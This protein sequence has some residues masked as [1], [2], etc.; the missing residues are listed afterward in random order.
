MMSTAREERSSAARRVGVCCT[1]RDGASH[2]GPC[3]ARACRAPRPPCWSFPRRPRAHSAAAAHAPAAR[4][5]PPAPL[6]PIS[7]AEPKLTRIGFCRKESTVADFFFKKNVW[8][9]RREREYEWS[10]TVKA[11]LRYSATRA[12]TDSKTNPATQTHL[13]V[14][15]VILR[16]INR[17]QRSSIGSV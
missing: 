8:L 4:P 2:A 10:E 6:L 5:P 3:R 13:W 12:G 14:G 9:L 16:L 15:T 7:P 17:L 1:G 11:D